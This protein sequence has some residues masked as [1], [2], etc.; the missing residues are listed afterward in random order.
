MTGNPEKQTSQTIFRNSRLGNT[1][2]SAWLND[3]K[4]SLR[5]T[6]GALPLLVKHVRSERA[7]TLKGSLQRQT[8]EWL[9]ESFQHRLMRSHLNLDHSYPEDITFKI[10]ESMEE[11]ERACSLL[12]EAYAE[13]GFTNI[14]G[15]GSRFTVYHA[16]PTSYTLIAKQGD[17]IL[18]TGTLIVRTTDPL[19]AEDMLA[20]EK[21]LKEGRRLVEVSAL[22]IHR[23]ARG[24]EGRILFSFFKYG[25][26]F[27]LRHLGA[28]DLIF[29]C[30]PAQF[31]F[32]T[33]ILLFEPIDGKVVHT[34]DR[35]NG[36]SRGR[37]PA[38]PLDLARKAE[39][40]IR[41]AACSQKHV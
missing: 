2:I 1:G 11:I 7:P 20:L 24:N 9:P 26:T 5:R 32:Y 15:S 10:V 36:G 25:Y 35:V 3:V 13:V 4:T 39:A 38:G 23:R 27:A 12:H 29:T 41:R 14:N 8:F 30:V 34:N 28:T 37:G 31:A 22:A 6:I 17:D 33:G 16:M 19:P 18:A 40:H 21:Y